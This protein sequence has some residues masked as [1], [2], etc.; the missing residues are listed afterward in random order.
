MTTKIVNVSDIKPAKFN[1]MRRTVNTS[2]NGLKAS[3]EKHGRPLMPLLVD[4]DM[5]L[6]DGHRRLACCKELG[7]DRVEVAVIDVDDNEALWTEVNT[8]TKRIGRTDWTAAYLQGMSLDAIPQRLAFEI[9]ETERLIGR[10]HLKRIT[11]G[12]CRGGLYTV[13][14]SIALY[15]S[16]TSD[17]FMR[18]AILYMD[19][20][21]NQYLMRRAIAS[22]V[23]PKVLRQKILRNQPV[24]LKVA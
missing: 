12:Q 23:N 11:D 6:I 18:A 15:V 2:L 20:R 14:K 1:P 21:G 17:A 4:G 16:D 19:K 24:S 22:S 3:I 10:D 5:N 8:T 9:L 13:A 7:I